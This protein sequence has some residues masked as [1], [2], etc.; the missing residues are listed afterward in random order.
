MSVRSFDATCLLAFAIGIGVIFVAYGPMGFFSRWLGTRSHIDARTAKEEGV[1][2]WITG[3]FE[4]HSFSSYCT[5]K[6]LTRSSPF[7]LARNS[8]R[9]GTVYPPSRTGTPKATMRNESIT[10]RLGLA[11]YVR[12]SQALSQS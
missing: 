12:S 7:G 1:P 3:T 5:L 8:L 9:V 11:P 2:V 4:S 10:D 6:V